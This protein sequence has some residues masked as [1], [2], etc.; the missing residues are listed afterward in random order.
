MLSINFLTL[1]IK[2]PEKYSLQNRFFLSATAIS[3]HPDN[4]IFTLSQKYLLVPDGS[5]LSYPTMALGWSCRISGH[6]F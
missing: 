6:F 2:H 3:L 5:I 1:Q 4:L